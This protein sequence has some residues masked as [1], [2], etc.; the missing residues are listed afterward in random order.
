M[1]R[2]SKT[3]KLIKTVFKNINPLTCNETKEQVTIRFDKNIVSHFRKSGKGWQTRM[4]NILK[5][6]V[7]LQPWPTHW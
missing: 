3:D 7:E 2:K 6:Y 1:A 4:N 5:I